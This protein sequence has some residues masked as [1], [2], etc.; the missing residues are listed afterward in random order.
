[1]GGHDMESGREDYS[2]DRVTRDARL[3]SLQGRAGYHGDGGRLSQKGY[4]AEGGVPLGISTERDRHLGG[5]GHSAPSGREVASQKDPRLD[6]SVGS[7]VA[8]SGH[9]TGLEPYRS[10]VLGYSS[11]GPKL[12]ESGGPGSNWGGPEGAQ[13]NTALGSGL[14]HVVIPGHSGTGQYLERSTENQPGTPAHTGRP[15]GQA[16]CRQA[17]LQY[18]ISKVSLPVLHFAHR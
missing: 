6:L 1:M 14:E 3:S 12:G 13:Y 8:Q 2:G 5:S 15:G 16:E 4:C 10:S 18:Y 17:Q 9:H 7:E 11:R